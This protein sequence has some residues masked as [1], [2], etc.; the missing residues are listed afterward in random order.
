M[1]KLSESVWGDIRKKS[2]GQEE[3]QEIL[4]P[5]E[6]LENENATVQQLYTYLIQNYKPTG[7]REI[8]LESGETWGNTWYEV[9]IPVS[10]Q[11][12]E[13]STEAYNDDFTKIFAVDFQKKLKRYV[14]LTTHEEIESFNSEKWDRVYLSDKSFVVCNEIVDFLDELLNIVPDPALEKKK[15]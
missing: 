2:L 15:R 7:E 3:R 11:Y 13:I 12:G 1:K 14:L 10:L 6:Q 8:K 4:V 5:Y 9:Y